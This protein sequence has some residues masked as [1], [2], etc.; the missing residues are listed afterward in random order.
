MWRMRN[1]MACCIESLARRPARDVVVLCWLMAALAAAAPAFAVELWADEEGGR[2]VSMDTAL[3][4]SLV[5]S[6]N[7][8]DKLFFPER[9]TGVGLL[10]G[11]LTFNI[12]LSDTMNAEFA[13]EQ[14]AQFTPGSSAGLSAGGGVLPSFGEA[15]YRLAQL[16]WQIAK[17]GD[18]SIYRHEIDRG[19]VAFH[20]GWGEV[21]IGRQAIGLG[22]GVLFGAVDVFAPF[23]PL[24]VDREWRRGIDALRV[25]Y[26][27]S[28]TSSM[29]LLGAFGKS[30]DESALLLRVRGYVGNID[31]E[32]IL[33]KRGRDA[34]VG[35]AMSA[36]VGDAEV[37]AELAM[38]DT[39][40]A[41]PDGGLFGNDHL[42]A[43]AVLGSSYTFD[44]GN[45]LTLLGE[46]HYSGFGVE[47]IEDAVRRLLNPDYVERYLRGD[48]QIL[49]QHALAVQLT[50]PFTNT[51]GGALLIFESLSDGSGLIAPSLRWDLSSAASL[52]LSTFV[53]WGPSPNRGRLESEYGAT[54]ASV[55]LQLS[56]YF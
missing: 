1:P 50:Y 53:P 5:V 48:T 33:G 28:D 4:S 9:W 44:V 18:D 29:E 24:E 25:E 7:P 47:D 39:P 37:H 34:M 6:H 26:Q 32:L 12:Q 2:Y 49:G 54:P 35:L 51:L 42:I 43:K 36:A 16:D 41:H 17:D 11:R 40:E 10:R 8:D 30:W 21:T 56:A 19:L 22:R 52:T 3:K 20:P 55:F 13:Y 27:L 45:G 23:S 31:G 46:Y 14:R 38:F 15:P